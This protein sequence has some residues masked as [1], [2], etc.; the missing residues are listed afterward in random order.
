VSDVVT[1]DFDEG[2][3]W[4]IIYQDGDYKAEVVQMPSL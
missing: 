1:D 3:R 4:K 2:K